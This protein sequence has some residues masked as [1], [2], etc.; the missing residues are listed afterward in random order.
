MNFDDGM[1]LMKDPDQWNATL[2]PDLGA[3]AEARK[4]VTPLRLVAGGTALVAV[5]IVATCGIF[6]AGAL[7]PTLPPVA[8]PA[9]S[10]SSG[11]PSSSPSASASPEPPHGVDPHIVIGQTTSPSDS[12]ISTAGWGEL[13]LGR[14]VPDRYPF[15]TFDDDFCGES[16]AWVF[17]GHK[18]GDQ[19]D[20][21]LDT[22]NHDGTGDVSLVIIYDEKVMTPSG[23]HVGS[24]LEEAQAAVPE[25]ELIR[26]YAGAQFWGLT[27]SLGRIVFEFDGDVIH[28]IQVSSPEIG[29][30][31]ALGGGTAGTCVA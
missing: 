4:R 8:L 15:A 16:G 22:E 25:L 26:E 2:Q 28:D 11:L 23:L 5:A 30:F 24:T 21:V 1:N 19:P 3:L 10:S 29:P 20:Y 7:Q 31:S 6:L 13:K 14:P 18:K 9:P 17:E 27:D 12:V